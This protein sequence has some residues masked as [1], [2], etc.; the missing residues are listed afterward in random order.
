M[1]KEEGVLFEAVPAGACWFHQ[2]TMRIAAEKPIG[3]IPNG[4]TASMCGLQP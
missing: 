1:L 2:F 3:I 4:Y